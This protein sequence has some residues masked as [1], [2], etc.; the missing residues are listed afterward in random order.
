MARVVLPRSIGEQYAGGE[1][2]FEIAGATVRE[3][4]RALDARFPGLG[5]MIDE[6][7]AVAVDGEILQDPDFEAVQPDSELFVLPKIGGGA[8]RRE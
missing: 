3:I 6:A 2:E 7:M 5:E 8:I 4:V 1:T